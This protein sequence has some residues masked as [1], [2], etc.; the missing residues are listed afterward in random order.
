MHFLHRLGLITALTTYLLHIHLRAY[1]SFLPSC[2]TSSVACTF[3]CIF[4]AGLFTKLTYEILIFPHFLSPLRHIPGP[5][6]ISIWNGQFPLIHKQPSGQPLIKWLDEVPNDGLIRYLAFCNVERIFPTNPKVLQEVMHTKG[7][8]FQKAPMVRRSIG[9]LLGMHGMLFSEGEQHKAQRRHMLPAFSYR[10]L[11]DLIPNFWGKSIDLSKAIENE[12]HLKQDADTEKQTSVI[13]EISQWL[14]RATLDIIGSAG[15]GYEFNCINNDNESNE[16][17]Q[18]YRRVF[19]PAPQA[20]QLQRVIF[21][22]LPEWLVQLIPSKRRK[23]ATEAIEIVKD[24]CMRM[25]REKKR[26]YETGGK[27]GQKGMLDVHKEP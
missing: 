2:L 18:A 27:M 15:F 11:R 21:Q 25:V 9:K 7:Y 14:N 16:L 10:H 26:E 20:V 13:I 19:Q 22:H 6:S 24:M 4:S 1:T 5:K 23:E 8:I 3:V 12:L 17:A